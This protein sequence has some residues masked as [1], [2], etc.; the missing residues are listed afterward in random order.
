MTGTPN[1]TIL[2]ISQFLQLEKS[3][4][5]F[6]FVSVLFLSLISSI[7]LT[8]TY[9][10]RRYKYNSSTEEERK[11]HNGYVTAPY[12]MANINNWLNQG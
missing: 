8:L 4:Y 1:F 12:H 6:L 10:I 9:R 2:Y 3:P 11:I 7:V 5:L